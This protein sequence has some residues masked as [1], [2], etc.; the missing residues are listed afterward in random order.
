MSPIPE[1][2]AQSE[3]SAADHFIGQ[4]TARLTDKVLI[5]YNLDDERF[6]RVHGVRSTDWELG[7]I[8]VCYWSRDRR[9]VDNISPADQATEELYKRKKLPI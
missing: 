1:T 3:Y 5:A 7:A 2:L 8:V 9:Y 6:Y 4:L